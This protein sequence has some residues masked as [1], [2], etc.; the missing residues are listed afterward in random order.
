[1]FDVVDEFVDG[2]T[3]PVLWEAVDGDRCWVVLKD[4]E[5]DV[6]LAFRPAVTEPEDV[7]LVAIG[8]GLGVGFGLESEGSQRKFL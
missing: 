6:L 2:W 4:V 8:C 5:R 3:G 7:P 1:M